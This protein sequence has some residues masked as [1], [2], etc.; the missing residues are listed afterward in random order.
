MQ[1]KLP[2]CKD[3]KTKHRETFY[4]TVQNYLPLLALSDKVLTKHEI[5]ERVLVT[6]Q[7]P[8]GSQSSITQ[9]VQ[10]WRFNYGLCSAKINWHS[11]LDDNSA[12]SSQ[13][14]C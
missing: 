2:K 11:Y 3:P 7:S 14:Y 9:A 5:V 12:D 1:G 13:M 4:E 6:V 10:D 8:T